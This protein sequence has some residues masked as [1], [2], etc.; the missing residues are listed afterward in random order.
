MNGQSQQSLLFTGTITNSARILKTFK[1]YFFKKGGSTAYVDS[2]L[3]FVYYDRLPTSKS[4]LF[5]TVVTWHC[6]YE[7]ETGTFI[8]VGIYWVNK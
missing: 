3:K 7:E 1:I 4:A 5:D 6:T 8:S 2:N